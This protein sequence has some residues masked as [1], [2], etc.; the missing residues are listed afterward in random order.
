M[1]KVT[2]TSPTVALPPEP[3]ILKGIIRVLLVS[4]AQ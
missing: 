2:P 1:S 3:Q 4:P